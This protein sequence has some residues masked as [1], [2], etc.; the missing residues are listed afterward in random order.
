MFVVVMAS[1]NTS[2][3]NGQIHQKYEKCIKTPKKWL[4]NVEIG[5]LLV[6]FT[7]NTLRTIENGNEGPVLHGVVHLND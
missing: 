2:T 3:K 1:P 5:A 4:E 7:K 6:L